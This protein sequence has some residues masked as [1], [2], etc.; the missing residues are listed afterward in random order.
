MLACHD[1]VVVECDAE[2]AVKVKTW[3]E[4]AMS[5]GMNVILND[6][7]EVHVSVEVEARIS[8]SWGGG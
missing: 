2:Q 3:M 8:E 6:R 7:A 4:K 1:E 5:D